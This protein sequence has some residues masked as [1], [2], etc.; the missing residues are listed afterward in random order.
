M[1]SA[2]ISELLG[3]LFLWNNGSLVEVSLEI[4]IQKELGFDLREGDSVVFRIL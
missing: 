4:H 2:P 1:S 3:V